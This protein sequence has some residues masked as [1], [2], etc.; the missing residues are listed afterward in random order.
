MP[1]YDYWDIEEILAEEKDVVIK[2]LH[3]ISRGG[4]LYPCTGTAKP[5]DLK[6]GA[7]ATQSQ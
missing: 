5:L 2:S 4:I 3:D 1:C 7:K 6:E